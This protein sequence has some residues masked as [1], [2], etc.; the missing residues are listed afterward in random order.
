VAYWFT[1]LAI[2]KTP[3]AL[4]QTMLVATS[5]VFGVLL[6]TWLVTMQRHHWPASQS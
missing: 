3:A 4:L 1:L 2:G 6:I 5:A